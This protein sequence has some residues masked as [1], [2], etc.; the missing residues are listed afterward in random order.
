MNPKEIFMKGLKRGPRAS[1]GL[2]G[3]EDPES[4]SQ[5]KAPLHRAGGK[6]ERIPVGSA[7]SVVTTD[8]MEKIGVFF[9]EAHV[10]AEKMAALAASGHT[11]LGFDNVMPL[12]SVW[13]ECAALGCR[14]NWGDKDH[15]PDFH[16]SLVSSINDDIEIPSDFLKRPSCAVPLEAIR[17]LKNQFQDEVAIVG[18]VFGPWTLA[19]HVFGVQEFLIQTIADPDGVKKALRKLIPVTVEF[20]NAQ[21]EA[22][23]DALTLGDHCTRDLCSPQAYKE[24]LQGIH[25]ELNENIHCPLILHIC[26]DTSDRIPMIRET[27]I[28]CFH[29]D[30]KVSASEAR[31]LAG[32]T[33]S[34]MGGTSNIDVILNGTPD[35]IKKDVQEKL[36]NN[37]DI[38][39][40]EC[41]VPLNAPYENLKLLVEQAKKE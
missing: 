17:L 5:I 34:L 31:D 8:L 36:E 37:I 35:M 32:D 23:A 2:M 29:Y 30:S 19:Y 13:H 11:E 7:T 26:G 39:G 20:G 9:P 33:L 4:A 28:E 27:G 21:I 24:F 12:F 3:S 40:P 22:G 10:D 18:K 41:A 38:I 16:G 14:V 25:K 6:T 15:M 1:S